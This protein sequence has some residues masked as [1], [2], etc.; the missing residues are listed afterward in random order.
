M[1]YEVFAEGDCMTYRKIYENAIGREI[2][3][4]WEIH[5]I[6]RNRENNNISNLVAMPRDFHKEYHSRL[7][8]VTEAEQFF[9]LQKELTGC[10]NG[11]NYAHISALHK[12]EKEFVD[13]FYK[14]AAF[15]DYRDY[16][17]G[18]LPD[19]H[20]IDEWVKDNE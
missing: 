1:V 8:K 2:P 20:G 6:D 7:D 13:I 17:L 18:L 10:G 3:K 14:C 4:G 9:P 5:H 16:L 12:A 15:I 19:I 11:I